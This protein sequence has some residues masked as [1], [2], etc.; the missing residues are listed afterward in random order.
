MVSITQLD[1]SFGLYE[2][3]LRMNLPDL[4]CQAIP[5]APAEQHSLGSWL[6]CYLVVLPAHLAIAQLPTKTCQLAKGCEWDP[7]KARIA[8]YIWAILGLMVVLSLGA[9][10]GSMF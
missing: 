4:D 1:C 7:A 8:T 2:S 5:A 3:T 6:D 9:C 10:C